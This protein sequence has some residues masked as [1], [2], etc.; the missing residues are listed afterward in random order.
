MATLRIAA[1]HITQAALL[2]S[3]SYLIVNFAVQSD[4]NWPWIEPAFTPIHPFRRSPT[5][6]MTLD[7]DGAYTT[8]MTF[9]RKTALQIKLFKTTYL[10]QGGR[11]GY[12]TIYWPDV[13]GDYDAYQGILQKV[14]E[15][16]LRPTDRLGMAPDADVYYDAPYLFCDGVAV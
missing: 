6:D 9:N 10:T 14:D 12:V 11:W 1:G 13:Y 16:A 8:M 4:Q 5:I 3:S 15:A 7:E 2:A